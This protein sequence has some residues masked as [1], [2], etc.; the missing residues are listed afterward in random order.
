[1]SHA[2]YGMECGRPEEPLFVGIMLN[3]NDGSPTNINKIT[4]VVG[5]TERLQI[6]PGIPYKST[7]GV[8][9]GIGGVPLGIMQAPTT[10]KD[11]ICL[12]RY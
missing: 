3:Q 9:L 1:M 7:G 10:A 2:N 8:P 5:T 12:L 11:Y 6:A 4:T